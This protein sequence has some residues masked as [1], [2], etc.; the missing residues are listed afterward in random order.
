MLNLCI[1]TWLFRAGWLRHEQTQPAQYGVTAPKAN[2]ATQLQTVLSGCPASQSTSRRLLAP[3][4]RRSEFR[5]SE[6][7]SLPLCTWNRMPAER[8]YVSQAKVACKNHQGKTLRHSYRPYSPASQ[9]T[10]PRSPKTRENGKGKRI[11]SQPA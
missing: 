6:P 8:R 10:R 7:D 5:L 4:K 3:E 1:Y 2:S 11:K 9:S